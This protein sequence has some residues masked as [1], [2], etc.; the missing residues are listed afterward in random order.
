MGSECA[1]GNRL[2]SIVQNV[3]PMK[4]PGQQSD[5]FLSCNGDAIRAL[6]LKKGWTQAE[7]AKLSGYTTRLIQKAEKG[8]ALAPPSLEVL[9]KTLSLDGD[10]V[11]IDQLTSTPLSVVKEFIR[12]INES[13]GEAG[14]ASAHIFSDDCYI[15]CAGNRE[16]VPFA[17]EWKGREGLIQ[18]FRLFHAMLTP[19]KD[20]LLQN[21]RYL[22]NGRHV[23]CWAEA[24]AQVV[25]MPGEMP[26]VWVNHLYEVR[27]GKITKY[28]NHFDTETGSEHLAEAKARNLLQ[29]A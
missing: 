6:R 15:W 20:G 28:E 26:V 3:A 12:H 14:V 25:G 21:A 19:S 17:G 13:R 5:R 1:A 16:Q 23:A 27:S 11:S 29:S 24:H 8:G 7:F 9:A 2:T 22:A 10:V 4:T 18:Y